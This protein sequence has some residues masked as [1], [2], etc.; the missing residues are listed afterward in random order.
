MA[1]PVL[2]DQDVSMPKPPASIRFYDPLNSARP[3][4][5]LESVGFICSLIQMIWQIVGNLIE[6]HAEFS[7][8]VRSEVWTNHLTKELT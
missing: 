2:V 4:C 6:L 5:T 7:V 8:R 1:L 3:L